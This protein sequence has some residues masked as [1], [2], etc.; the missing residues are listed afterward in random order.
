MS[1]TL[2][3]PQAHLRLEVKMHSLSP[4]PDFHLSP[5]WEPLL[6]RVL[7]LATP[8]NMTYMYAAP[9]LLQELYGSPEVRTHP[10][11]KV[12]IEPSDE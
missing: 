4:S 7:A 8:P 6:Q 10:Y 2:M 12:K 3:D 1:V 5:S 9:H 11:V